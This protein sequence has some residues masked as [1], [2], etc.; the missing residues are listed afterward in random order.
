MKSTIISNKW[1]VISYLSGVSSASQ[2]FTETPEW[3]SAVHNLL[4]QVEGGNESVDSDCAEANAIA[5]HT[6]PVELSYLC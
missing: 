5:S 6:T 1:E 2:F 3:Y 4:S